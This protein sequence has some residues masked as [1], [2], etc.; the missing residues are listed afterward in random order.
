MVTRTVT[1]A[2]TIFLAERMVA[3]IEEILR[4]RVNYKQDDWCSLIPYLL[5]VLNNQEK[6]ALLG[7]TPMQVELGIRPLTPMDLV[8]AVTTA[9]AE[10]VNSIKN[11]GK[12]SDAENR[13]AEITAVRE[14]IAE[15]IATVQADQKKYAD[16]RRRICDQLIKPGAK[17]YCSMPIKQ[18]L[19]QGLRP[20]SKLAHQRFGPFKVL[21]RVGV[22]AFELDL[23]NAASKQTI[24]VFHVKYLTAA[25]TGPYKSPKEAL[26]PGPVTGEA[27]TAEAEYELQRIIDR[28][29]RYKKFEYLV[30]YKG[31]PLH[32]DFEWRPQA[33][34]E[35]C[36]GTMLKNFNE[37]FDESS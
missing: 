6:A 14:S 7:K 9:K 22:N 33:E 4:T 23:G 20:S 15:D 12:V 27:G 21:H 2:V 16:D 31:Y 37:L 8:S 18:M 10:K 35:E 17:A 34:L 13:I 29:M 28:R 32:R 1:K 36:A 24:P 26:Q 30:E 11:V 19:A 25:P 5:F 3:V